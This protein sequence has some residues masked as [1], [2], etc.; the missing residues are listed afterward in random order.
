MPVMPDDRIYDGV[1]TY[2]NKEHGYC[3]LEF[4]AENGTKFTE[5]FKIFNIPWCSPV[6]NNHA[7]GNYGRM[8]V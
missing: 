2:I 4:I 6:K 3:R 7:G 1:V 8:C 5:A